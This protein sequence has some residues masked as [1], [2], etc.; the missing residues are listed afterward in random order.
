MIDQTVRKEGATGGQFLTF[1]LGE[2]EYAIDILKVQEIR[3]HTPLTPLPNTPRFIKGVM[4]LRGAIV[5]VVGLRERFSLPSIEYGPLS[6]II[7]A[8]LGGKVV[9]LVVDAVSDVLT[10]DG[11]EIEPT[12]ELGAAVNISFIRGIARSGDKLVALLQLEDAIGLDSISPA[13]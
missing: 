9:G 12:P 13:A 7:V 2:E 4:N 1:R 8:L 6:V 11:S 10:L 5:P 3:S